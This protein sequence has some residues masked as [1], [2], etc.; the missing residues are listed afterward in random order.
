MLSGRDLQRIA[1]VVKEAE[2]APGN[3]GEQIAGR[4]VHSSPEVHPVRV[5][6]ATTT[7]GRYPGKILSYDSDA[8]TFADLA[9]CWVV[10]VAGG[11]LG[12]TRYISRRVG[13]AN[14]RPVF[15]TLNPSAGGS[16]SIQEYDGSSYGID[17]FSRSTLTFDSRYGYDINSTTGDLQMTFAST[18]D[19]GII[20]DTGEQIVG[21]DF[22]T[23]GSFLMAPDESTY[24]RDQ[25]GSGYNMV[26]VTGIQNDGVPSAGD[27]HKGSFLIS[28]YLY[29]G[30]T[31]TF[32]TQF[33]FTENGIE[34]DGNPIGGSH[35]STHEPG[36]SDAIDWAGLIHASGTLASRPAAAA[37][38]AGTLYLVTDDDGG[39]IFRSNGSA[40]TQI[41]PG[42]TQTAAN[43]DT[44]DG[45]DSTDFANATHSGQHEPGGSDAIDWT[46]SINMSGTLAA[47][48]AAAAGN[49][50]ALYFATDDDG[51]TVYRSDGSSWTQIAP[52]NTQ[53]PASHNHTGV[54]SPVGHTHAASDI[55]SGLIALARGGGATDF[56]ATGPGY[57]KQASAGAVFT[58]SSIDKDDL[59]IDDTVLANHASQNVSHN[60]STYLALNSE[61]FD[62]GTL[63]DTS[64]NNSR[65]TIGENGTYAIGGAFQWASNATVATRQIEIVLNRTTVL[66]AENRYQ[67]FDVIGTLG[68]IYRLA[69]S[70]YIELRAYHFVG[71]TL[72]VSSC[73]LWA[74]KLAR[75]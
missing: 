64:T 68:G 44:L 52:G 12:V 28:L 11:A 74:H 2:T 73:A 43:A 60:T 15:M 51:G 17:L 37:G 50:G 21:V 61:L 70:D 62:V 9:D 4:R 69:A 67:E 13:D 29:T 55:A 63:H 71:S 32:L 58:V 14:S 7:D 10:D 46:G 34:Q 40:W 5:T 59:P 65:I 23:D 31:N 54:Y 16:I 36:G 8:K 75:Y 72:A 22:G 20:N 45:L 33:E 47:R 42:V 57:V 66:Y 3:R 48:P 24:W 26:Q 41:A 25:S 38:N 18:T 35:Q 19:A 49:A 56:S 27:P 1:K 39:T 30:S 6:S 53:E